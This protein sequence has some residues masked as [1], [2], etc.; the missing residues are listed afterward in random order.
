MTD[1]SW[2]QTFTGKKFYPL[3]P[4][5]D[6]ICI[7]DIAHSLAF[8]CRYSG[9]TRQFYSVAQHSVILS[10]KF[11]PSRSMRLA[12]LLH[13]AAEAYLSDIP[14]PIKQL[15]EF[16]FYREAEGRLQR[17]I[18][19]KFGVEL[20]EAEA[21]LLE[22]YDHQMIYHEAKSEQLMAPIHPDWKLPESTGREISIDWGW[23]P[24][25]AE[26]IFLIAFDDLTKNKEVAAA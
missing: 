5:P 2:I 12:A 9:H 3:N 7:E 1:N 8:Q 15:P 24:A 4:D 6:D 26:K 23:D 22:S 21:R 19:R 11:F 20:N 17:M 13:D 14:R 18:M 16:A 25:G 10:Q